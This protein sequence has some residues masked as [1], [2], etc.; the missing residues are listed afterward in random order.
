MDN[1][2]ILDNQKIRKR[3]LHDNKSDKDSGVDD[4]IDNDSN[5]G[6]ES[7]SDNKIIITW[8]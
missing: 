8:G 7:D 2:R 6:S 1:K 5:R 3:C 4:D